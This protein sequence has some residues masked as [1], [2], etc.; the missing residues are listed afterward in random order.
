[1]D[2]VERLHDVRRG[3][4]PLE[5]FAVGELLRVE[6]RDG[7]VARG[8]VV[9]GVDDYLGDE[10]TTLEELRADLG[11]PF[12]DFNTTLASL[13]PEYAATSHQAAHEQ[14]LRQHLALYHRSL[15]D[16]LR[17]ARIADFDARRPQPDW[18]EL[19]SFDW[20]TVPEAWGTTIEDVSRADL[21]ALVAD[22]I[23]ARLGR[24]PPVSGPGLSALDR[25]AA[26]N[27][28][29][30]TRAG[31]KVARLTRAWANAHRATVTSSLLSDDPGAEIAAS[32]D[33]NGV[34]DFRDLSDDDI[35]LA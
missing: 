28:T 2:V 19:R 14:A 33:A 21:T 17:W 24:A 25:V 26:A 13:A 29:L 10:G 5:Q 1:V 18:P 4:V 35:P 27:R 30:V 11:L 7:A 34:L 12:A 15:C 9:A 22:A 16:Q 6:F 20:V 3:Q 23:G 8:E 31:P 32:F